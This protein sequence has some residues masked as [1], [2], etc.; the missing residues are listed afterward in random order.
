[1][2]DKSKS[3]TKQQRGRTKK[4]RGKIKLEHT[5]VSKQTCNTIRIQPR[6]FENTCV[7]HTY[8]DRYTY[9]WMCVYKSV[10][11]KFAVERQQS[12]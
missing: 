1:M 5:S 3:K 10:D 2:Q 9:I 6:I 7:I 12:A 11:R 8:I 4:T